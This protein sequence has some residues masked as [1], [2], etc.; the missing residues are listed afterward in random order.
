MWQFSDLSEIEPLTRKH[1]R[2]AFSSGVSKLDN[3]IKHQSIRDAES[4][5]SRVF[6]LTLKKSPEIIVGY[7]SLSSLQV[8]MTGIAD[9]IKKQLPKYPV[10]GTTLL[11]KLA[12]DEK[13]Q[14]DKC[15]LKLGEHLLIDAMVKAWHANQ[16]V[17]SYAMIVDVL[18]GEKGD[19]TAFY[20]K[21]G[22][23]AFNDANAKHRLFLPMKTIEQTLQ[24]MGIIS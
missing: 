12:V 18:I 3:Y 23:Q 11:G 17:A 20:T 6:V 14:R 2:A 5:F 13:W 1:N 22:F 21:N 10:V 4:N 19:P 9:E 24:K 15:D 7:Y 16:L 8:S